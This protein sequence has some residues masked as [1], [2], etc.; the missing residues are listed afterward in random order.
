MIITWGFE[1]A[2]LEMQPKISRREISRIETFQKFKST[3]IKNMKNG[4]AFDL[5]KSLAS[6]C[7]R[8]NI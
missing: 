5:L 7:H 4:I 8:L 6:N 3:N 1:M 2:H